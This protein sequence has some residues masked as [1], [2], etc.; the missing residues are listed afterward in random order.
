M[1][2]LERAPP[3]VLV[4]DDDAMVLEIVTTR[5]T[6]AGYQTCIARDGQSALQRLRDTRPSALLLDINMPRLDGFG[7][8]QQMNATGLIRT[9]PTMVLTARNQ[10]EDVKRALALGARDYLAK[11]FKDAQLIARVARLLRK[12]EPPS[13]P[14][15]IRPES[16]Q[17]KAAFEL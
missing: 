17:A 12:V 13:D 4:V 1:R 10:P 2:L 5:L 3:R 7:V 14:A 6:L 9:V 8:L 16:I 11:P 15:G